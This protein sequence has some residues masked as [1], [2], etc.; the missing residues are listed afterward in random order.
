[1]D[2]TT[3]S[4]KKGMEFLIH[5]YETYSGALPVDLLAR[6]SQV[7]MKATRDEILQSKEFYPDL[8]KFREQY[9]EQM[10]KGL[11][12]GKRK[13]DTAKYVLLFALITA[14]SNAFMSGYI[15]GGAPLP[16]DEEAKQWLIKRESE[17]RA[18]LLGLLATLAVLAN[19]DGFDFDAWVDARI[20][21]YVSTL[22]GVYNMGKM[23]A[24][25]QSKPKELFTLDGEDGVEHCETCKWLKTQWKPASWWLSNDYIPYPGN[26]NLDCKGYKCQHFCRDKHGNQLTIPYKSVQVETPPPQIA[27]DPVNANASALKEHNPRLHVYAKGKDIFTGNEMV[28][29]LVDGFW[30][31]CNVWTDFTAAGN[32]ARYPW[33]PENEIW[34]DVDDF[35]EWDINMIHETTE[36]YH[37][38]EDKMD[39]NSAHAVANK[40][41]IEARQDMSKITGMLRSLGWIL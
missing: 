10:R 2:N 25:A 1:M 40:S 39:Y 30:I 34:L 18:Y 35:K 13:Q 19:Q 21:G 33:C 8:T 23:Y 20:A 9:K 38:R 41:E 29:Y 26:M 28:A 16:V 11:E 17:E 14:F 27:P 31:R 6:V 4:I 36:M 24:L 22:D 32:H 12:Q 15:D 3:L 37:M 5:Y 7:E